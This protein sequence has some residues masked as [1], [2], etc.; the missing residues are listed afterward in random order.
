MKKMLVLLVVATLVAGSAL[1]AVAD[2]GPAEI[3][4]SAK[5]G[6]ITFPH[7]KHQGIEADCTVCH[8]NG[9]EEPNCHSCHG[10]KDDAPDA[11]KVFHQLCKD[12]HK[13]AGGNAP[14][15]CKGC[16]VK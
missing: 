3:K 6:D 13:E 14:T 11:K 1:V 7:E 4:L 9:V 10:A 16:H 8:H 15:K 2:N 5:M 12:C